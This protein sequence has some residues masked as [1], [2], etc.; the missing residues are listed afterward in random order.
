[1]Q[2]NLMNK[3]R[4]QSI[5]VFSDYVLLFS[6]F[7]SVSL[8]PLSAIGIILSILLTF[9]LIVVR[10]KEAVLDIKRISPFDKHSFIFFALICQYFVVF[11]LL[12][13]ISPSP[14]GFHVEIA[15]FSNSFWVQVGTI[16][17]LAMW[18]IFVT[19]DVVQLMNKVL[20]YALL[21]A[22]ALLTFDKFSGIEFGH[23]RCRISGLNGMPFEP[24]LFFGGFT[25]LSFLPWSRLD[26]RQKMLRIALLSMSVLIANGYTGA[27]FISLVIFANSVL[28][29]F[30]LIRQDTEK[31]WGVL[32]LFALVTGAL[33]SVITDMVTNCNL[34]SRA[35][36][37]S[38]VVSENVDKITDSSINRRRDLLTLGL[39]AS[40]EI[41]FLGAGIW[42][43]KK[44]I[45]DSGFSQ[46]H[47][48][49][50]YLSWVQWGGVVGLLSGGL[51]LLSCLPMI[52]MSERT[53]MRNI[54]FLAIVCYLPW[55]LAADTFMK[56][57]GY[58]IFSL[59][60]S[61]FVFLSL[62]YS[63]KPSPNPSQS[64][65]V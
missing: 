55:A 53:V 38:T 8:G 12:A 15:Y 30:V 6:I 56:N 59:S 7:L 63:Q 39:T 22:F 20:P 31:K 29:S 33:F 4:S 37:I 28:L 49:N 54:A 2:G 60:M 64:E 52:L 11:A 3:S 24:A 50:Q 5:L 23:S 21:I 19:T 44:L 9:F 10:S 46:N 36:S 58:L 45:L 14:E 41:S 17:T 65:D 35:L 61:S 48:H 25:L 1:M 40:K 42:S 27:R 51:F 34:I 16:C 13:T 43:E 32:V 47:F 18:R 26:T 62:R 57:E